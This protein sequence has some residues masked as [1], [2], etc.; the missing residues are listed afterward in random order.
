MDTSIQQGTDVKIAVEGLNNVR[1]AALL[2]II[3]SILGFIAEA[4]A[5]IGVFSVIGSVATGN[6]M[7]ALASVGGILIAALIILFVGLILSLIAIFAKFIPGLR[8]L[9]Q[10]N[11][12]F[13]TAYTLT[14]IG[15]IIGLILL[16]VGFIAV[17]PLAAIGAMSGSPTVAMGS[18]FA[19]LGLM[20]IG[21]IFL[22][23]GFIGIIVSCFNM[24]SVFGE[25]MYMIAGI[26]LIL[27]L[28]L[29]II[30]IFVWAASTVSSILYLIAWILI[31]ITIP[32][33]I[34]KIEAP[35]VPQ[36]ATLL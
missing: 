5:V 18:I 10:W 12:E 33:T 6:L 32:K 27:S 11:Q 25:S 34:A 28:I 23:I 15:M 16:L 31:Y 20:I 36:T 30:G 13:S 14:R 29:G 3:T 7:E 8:K 35:Q 9:K 24:N 2:F 17:I 26:L 22:F 19:A 4:I 1:G 21:A